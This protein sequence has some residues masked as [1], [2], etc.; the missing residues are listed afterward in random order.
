MVDISNKLSKGPLMKKPSIHLL[1]ASL[2]LIL[3]AGITAA[4]IIT[5]NADNLTN[6]KIYGVNRVSETS[7]ITNRP[8]FTATFKYGSG[9]TIKG[10][11]VVITFS[12]QNTI[13]NQE[14]S[15]SGTPKR[16]GW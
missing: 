3:A 14:T 9:W 7:L 1:L 12:E 5:I 4:T 8:D 13:R 6:T 11:V 15:A 16:D 10:S 2:S